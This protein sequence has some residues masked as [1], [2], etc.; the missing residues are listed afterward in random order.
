[1]TTEKPELEK[2]DTQGSLVLRPPYCTKCKKRLTL[3]E[4]AFNN[5][6]NRCKNCN[7]K[8]KIN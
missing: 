6:E 3:R 7:T 4:I 2:N 1:M 5:N 8:I